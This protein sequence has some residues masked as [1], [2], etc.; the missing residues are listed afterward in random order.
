MDTVI[1]SK[2]KNQFKKVAHKVTLPNNNNNNNN[3]KSLSTNIITDRMPTSTQTPRNQLRP[4]P[5]KV[6]T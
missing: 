5:M 4:R 1:I 2:N 3:N 6:S